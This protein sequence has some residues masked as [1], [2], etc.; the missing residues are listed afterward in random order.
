MRL[1]LVPP[2][3][4]TS[5]Q[6]PLYEDMEAGI[7]AKYVAFT[8]MR[9]ASPTLALWGAD[10]YAVGRLFDLLQVWAEMA[11]DL[12]THAIPQWNICRRRNSRNRQLPLVDFLEDRVGRT[13]SSPSL[14]SLRW[15]SSGAETRP[16]SLRGSEAR[17]SANGHNDGGSLRDAESH[18][19]HPSLPCA[20]VWRK[21]K[22]LIT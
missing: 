15:A 8:T 5:E 18:L 16:A 14:L 4:L 7:P 12:R 3:N 11:G 19:A 20:F 6:L 1:A 13:G 21:V 10:H 17:Q 9:N 22:A 2:S